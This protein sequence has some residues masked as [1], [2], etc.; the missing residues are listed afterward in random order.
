MITKFRF[1]IISIVFPIISS[2]GQKLEIADIQGKNLIS[3]FTGQSVTLDSNII[4]ATGPGY[5]FIQTPDNRKPSPQLGSYGVQVYTGQ[6]LNFKSGDWVTLTGTVEEYLSMTRIVSS[7][8]QIKNLGSSGQIPMAVELRPNFPSPDSIDQ[9]DLEKVEGMIIKFT[10]KSSAPTSFN[11]LTPLTI[12][13]R[14]FREPGIVYPG[15]QGLPVWDGNPEIF[16]FDPDGLS[17]LP[18]IYVPS[19]TTVEATAIITQNGTSYRA[20]PLEYK[21]VELPADRPVRRPK[22]NEVCIGSFNL[23]QE[24][25]SSANFDTRAEK[26]AAYILQY[27]NAPDIIALQEVTGQNTLDKLVE[28]LNDKQP[29]AGYK[30]YLGQGTDQLKVAYLVKSSFPIQQPPMPLGISERFENGSLHDRPPLLLKVPISESI[31]L[32]LINI[33]MRSLNGIEGDRSDFVKGKRN[34]QAISV[35]RMLQ[36]FEGENLLVVGDFNAFPF[37]DGYVDV[38]NQLT[39]LTSL[40]AEYPTTEIISPPLSNFSTSN[41]S[42]QEQYSFTFE[43]NAELIDQCI[44]RLHTGL[45]LTEIQYGRGNADYPELFLTDASNTFHSSDHDGMVIYLDT[46]GINSTKNLQ[47]VNWKLTYP[48]PFFSGDCI[49]ISGLEQEQISIQ[50]LDSHGRVLKTVK[51]KSGDCLPIYTEPVS[52]GVYFIRSS[53]GK[54]QRIDKMLVV[55]GRP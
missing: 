44:G 45:N 40:G 52:K 41:L 36:G 14:P 30:G 33:H 37:S 16:W 7:P 47:P 38:T 8:S 9:P 11:G 21:V 12:G 25:S 50:L 28:K 49:Q 17:S 42:P 3:S 4:T 35:A 39:G 1:I 29:S 43:G 23:L 46:S 6:F 27:L 2:S 34:A 54:V 22:S 32:N 53:N 15:K 26:W 10:G 5:F 13:Q 51:G 18:N 55:G 20:L 48:S 31:Q 19:F 24:A